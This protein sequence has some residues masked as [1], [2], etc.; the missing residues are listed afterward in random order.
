VNGQRTVRVGV[1]LHPERLP[2]SRF[3][4]VM[5]DIDVLGVDTI[6]NWDHFFPLDGN[7][8]AHPLEAWTLLSAVATLTTHAEIGCLVSCASFRNPALLATMART[9][10]HISGGRLILGLG[11]GWFE[12]DFREYGYPFGSAA[13]RLKTLEQALPIIKQRWQ[14]DVPAPVRN[15]IPILIGGAGEKITLRLAAQ[16]ANIWNSFGP[17][18]V[19]RRKSEVL[20]NWCKK[21]VRDASEIERSVLV[22]PEDFP[23][24]DQY[25]TAGATH[26]IVT[27]PEPWDVAIAE[28]L[29]RWRDAHR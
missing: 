5:R 16:H 27:L 1:N 12:R 19:Y 24:L 28:Q 25:V 23:R 3:A 4:Q 17:A 6:W 21:V 20:D 29:V 7:P 26:I 13:Q 11:A 2:Y 9:V 14:V 22:M 15:P 18:D 10:D 8:R